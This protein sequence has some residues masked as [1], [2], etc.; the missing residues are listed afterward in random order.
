MRLSVGCK[1]LNVYETGIGAINLPLPGGV[2]R[3]HSKAVHPVSLIKMERFISHLIGEP[4]LI[5]NPFIFS[6]KAMMCNSI[7]CYPSLTFETISCDRL[8]RE[9]YIQCGYCSSCILRRQALMAAN[10]KDQT[11]YLIPHGK[12]PS[13]RHLI[14]WKLMNQQVNTIE[15]ALDSSEP[16]FNLS[17]SYPNDLSDLA[18]YLADRVNQSRYAI[19]EKIVKLYRTYVREW[20]GFAE[21]ILDDMTHTKNSEHYLEVGKWQQMQLIN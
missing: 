12:N 19:E 2:G 1:Q 5:D 17:M 20:R 4:F 21:Y 15:D 14:Y 18:Y 13:E 9:K 8:H 6:T 7:A 16:F 11:K 3:D 10:I